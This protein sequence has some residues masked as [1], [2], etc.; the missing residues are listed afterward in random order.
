[1]NLLWITN[2]TVGWRNQNNGGRLFQDEIFVSFLSEWRVESN[3]S[4]YTV[5]CSRTKHSWDIHEILAFIISIFALRYGL[6]FGRFLGFYRQLLNSHVTLRS[7][8]FFM[9]RQDKFNNIYISIV[10]HFLLSRSRL[11]ILYL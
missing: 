4:E 11:P 3:D 8:L 5:E 7:M 1:M 9:Y 10:A 2:K 6:R